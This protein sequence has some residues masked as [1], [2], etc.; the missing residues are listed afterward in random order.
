MG[1]ELAMR[2]DPGWA[3]DPAHAHDNRWMHRPLM[4]WDQAR[5]GG[6]DPDSLEGRVFAAIRGL[7]RAR[8]SLL[9]LRARR[10]R[11]DPPAE[12][13]SVLS[14]R[15]GASAQRAVPTR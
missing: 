8:R 4:D 7:A 12:H 3:G 14:Y 10:Q 1:D 9:A 2:S 13:R 15:R 6:N 5:R 11:R